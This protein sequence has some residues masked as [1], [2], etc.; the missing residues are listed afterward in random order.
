M[1]KIGMWLFLVISVI[2]SGFLVINGYSDFAEKLLVI[3]AVISVFD[4]FFGI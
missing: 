4:S 2:V 1:K 3:V